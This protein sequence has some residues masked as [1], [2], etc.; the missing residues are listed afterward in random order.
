MNMKADV[1]R[2]AYTVW[3]E[4]V[5]VDVLDEHETMN[6]GILHQENERK[7]LI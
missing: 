1:F 4:K 6:P 3:R 5:I 7:Q 2:R